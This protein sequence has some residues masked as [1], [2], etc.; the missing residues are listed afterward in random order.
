MLNSSEILSP[1]YGI[2]FC[3]IEI[4]SNISAEFTKVVILSACLLSA[5]C[6]Q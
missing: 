6:Y 5:V 1:V 3:I 4:V 2:S